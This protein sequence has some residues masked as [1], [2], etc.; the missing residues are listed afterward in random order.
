MSDL[1]HMLTPAER[2]ARRLYADRHRF[3]RLAAH[4]DDS[5]V[6]PTLCLNIAHEIVADLFGPTKGTLCGSASTP[7]TSDPVTPSGSGSEP[8]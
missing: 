1:P 2:I 7:N 3:A 8:S 5:D 4:V 6:W